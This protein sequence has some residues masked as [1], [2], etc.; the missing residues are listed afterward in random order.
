MANPTL[1][2]EHLKRANALIARIKDEIRAMSGDND[3]LLFAYRR[4]VY[5]ELSYW[6]R[7]KPMDRKRLKLRKWRAQGEACFACKQ[8]MAMAYAILDRHEAIG[9]YTAENTDLI[10]VGC[11]TGRQASKNYK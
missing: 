8:P 9:G 11:D 4:K 1:D 2:E 10:C 6:E 5:K 7:G 3:Q